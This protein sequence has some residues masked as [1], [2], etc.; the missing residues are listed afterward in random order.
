[1]ETKYNITNG[2]GK[3]ELSVALFKKPCKHTY[4][5]FK[6]D[7]PEGGK[8]FLIM[9]TIINTVQRE[10]GSNESWIIEGYCMLPEYKDAGRPTRSFTAYYHTRHRTGHITVTNE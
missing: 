5:D 3:F 1:M 8:P 10:D 6:V 4:I 2:P 7:D 9:S